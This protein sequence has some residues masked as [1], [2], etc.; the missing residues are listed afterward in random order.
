MIVKADSPIKSA[1]DLVGKRLAVNTLNN[2]NWLYAQAWIEQSGGDPSKV[3]FVEV[4]FPQMNDA[5]TNGQVDAAFNT[6]PFV[7]RGEASGQIHSIGRPFSE[8]QP[9]LPKA[10]IVTTGGFIKSKPEIVKHFVRAYLRGAEWMNAHR[11][12]KEWADMVAVITKLKPEIIM[13]EQQPALPTSVNVADA[14]KTIDLMVKYG[15][16]DKKIDFSSLLYETVK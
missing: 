8:V 13:K 5:V 7:T 10:Q 6:D 3:T 1:A 16:L 4:P 2:I 11:G 14:N 9:N 15:L 12:Q